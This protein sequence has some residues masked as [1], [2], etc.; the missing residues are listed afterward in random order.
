[1]KSIKSAARN[2][3]RYLSL[4][5]LSLFLLASLHSEAA[6][7]PAPAPSSLTVEIRQ[8]DTAGEV[9]QVTCSSKAK[10]LL[11]LDIQTKQ[12]KKETLTVHVTFVPGSVLFQFETP[13]GYLYS[14]DNN[15]DVQHTFYETIAHN[16]VVPNKPLTRDITLFLPA[17]RPALVAPLMKTVQQPVAILEITETAP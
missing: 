12:G 5:L 14:R 8:I 6:P 17:V 4:L 15:A 10:C 1:M 16:L 3:G 2:R 13:D 11:S 7:A 9:H